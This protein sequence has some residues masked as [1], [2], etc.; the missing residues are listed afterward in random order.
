V[1]KLALCI[2][3]A[4]MAGGRFDRPAGWIV[5]CQALIS[6]FQF[7]RYL[8][9]FD[10]DESGRFFPALRVMACFARSQEMILGWGVA[11]GALEL[12]FRYALVTIVAPGLGVL[13]FERDGM[14]KVCIQVYRGPCLNVTCRVGAK[15]RIICAKFDFTVAGCT[16]LVGLE[17]MVGHKVSLKVK[18]WLLDRF[19]RHGRRAIIFTYSHWQAVADVA[20]QADG[21]ALGAQVL[22]VVAAETAWGCFVLAVVWE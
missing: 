11:V 12:G 2:C 18:L 3:K 22:A 10:N 5:A 4:A 14:F 1:A 13:A 21:F 9:R 7:M 15:A 20:V 6:T 8:G 16:F 19:D 17:A